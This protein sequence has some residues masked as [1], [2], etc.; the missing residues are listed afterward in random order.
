[1]PGCRNILALNLFIHDENQII[2][3]GQ[4][5]Y[6]EENS[7]VVDHD[8]GKFSSIGIKIHHGNSWI[9]EDIII[10]EINE[11]SFLFASTKPI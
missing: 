5:A 7:L 1:M 8:A 10:F 4:K 6:G 2:G 3:K 9:E 11:L